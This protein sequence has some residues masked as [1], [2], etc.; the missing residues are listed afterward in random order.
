MGRRTLLLIASILVAAVG[1]ALVALYVR[2]AD[3][4]AREGTEQASVQFALRDIKVGTPVD[5]V[6]NGENA[7]VKT[8]AVNSVPTNAISDISGITGQ[9]TVAIVAGAPLQRSMFG[10]VAAASNGLGLDPDRVAASFELSDPQ[11]VA[12]VLQPGLFV[13]VYSVPT[14]GRV[15]QLLKSVKVLQIGTQTSA[16]SSSTT[17]TSDRT[18]ANADQVPRAVLTFNLRDEDEIKMLAAQQRGDLVLGLLG[19]QEIGNSP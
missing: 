15:R 2:G 1:T 7:G 13:S 16:S 8:V 6:F 19:N 5:Q 14:N 3:A 9:T 17:S 18:S 12:G 4:R 11:R 10:K